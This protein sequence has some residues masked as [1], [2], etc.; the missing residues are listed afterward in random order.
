[1]KIRTFPIAGHGRCVRV[2]T[3]RAT[4]WISYELGDFI[5]ARELKGDPDS[6]WCWSLREALGLGDDE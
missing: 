1:M 3:S 5:I 2:E 4:W 6:W